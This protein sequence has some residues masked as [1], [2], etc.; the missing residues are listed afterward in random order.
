MNLDDRK[1]FETNI[2]EENTF[3][4]NLKAIISLIGKAL[5]I[6]YLLN[7]IIIFGAKFVLDILNHIYTSLRYDTLRSIYEFSG[8]VI[9]EILTFIWLAKKTKIQNI[10]M[11]Y[12]KEKLGKDIWKYIS[13]LFT[14][15]LIGILCYLFIQIISI[16][17]G[18][19]WGGSELELPTTYVFDSIIYCLFVCIAAPV[20]EELLFRGAILK[21]LLPYGSKFAI[22][23]SAVLFG[24]IHGNFEQIPFALFAGLIFGYVSVKTDSL[25]Y[26]II[27]HIFNNSWAVA[28]GLFY[29]A[30]PDIVLN[31]SMIIILLIGVAGLIII[32]Q[33]RKEIIITFNKSDANCA[34]CANNSS[35]KYFFKSF[36]MWC[37][38]IIM[39]TFCLTSVMN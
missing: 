23:V 19:S 2:N 26:S 9:S 14:A 13:F 35:Y 38:L 28:Y 39:V 7:I 21:S 16:P 17:F 25:F 33:D 37:A 34:I 1:D 15:Q 4:N 24:M 6:N 32:L 18:I 29:T 12:K 30:A 27:L 36:W 22:I 20:G 31:I 5:I 11:I 10:N 8:T 3:K